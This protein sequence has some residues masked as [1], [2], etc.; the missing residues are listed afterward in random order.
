MEKSMKILFATVMFTTLVSFK[1]VAEQREPVEPLTMQ[2]L[3]EALKMSYCC[4]DLK[5]I[6]GSERNVYLEVVT[7]ES[8]VFSREIILM[9]GT[10]PTP[11][12]LSVLV[13]DDGD[14]LQ[15]TCFRFD[16]EGRH[17]TSHFTINNYIIGTKETFSINM[18]KYRLGEFFLF[19]SKQ[20]SIS[21][22]GS[23]MDELQGDV[24]LRFVAK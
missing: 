14:K 4:Y 22:N 13:R 6:A 7:Q 8:V 1:V 17:A 23:K 24:G 15:F 2:M 3:T 11:V 16:K 19:G 10:Y 20:K 5:P 9:K 18:G 12:S 21:F